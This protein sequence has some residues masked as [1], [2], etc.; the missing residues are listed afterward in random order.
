MTINIK[1]CVMVEVDFFRFKVGKDGI[2]SGTKVQGI[3]D[4]PLLKDV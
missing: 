4:F 1:K 3:V 2:K